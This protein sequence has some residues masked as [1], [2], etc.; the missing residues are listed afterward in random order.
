VKALVVEGGKFSIDE[1]YAKPAPER[2]EAVIKVTYAGICDT[3]VQLASG[4]L[5]FEGVA[6]HEFV[7]VVEGG[8]AARGR[9][10]AV[11]AALRAGRRPNRELD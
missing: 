9:R 1:S 7:G 10:R 2:D 6:G 4:Y 8:P 11:R 3:D 5:S